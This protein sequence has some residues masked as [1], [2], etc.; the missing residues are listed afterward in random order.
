[1][2]IHKAH[3]LV[4]LITSKIKKNSAPSPDPSLKGNQYSDL[5]HHR[6]VLPVCGL[7]EVVPGFFGSRMFAEL[8]PSMF[9]LC[10]LSLQEGFPIAEIYHNVFIC[11]RLMDSM[12]VS[13]FWLLQTKLLWTLVACS[14]I[15][16][17]CGCL[18]TDSSAFPPVS[19]LAHRFYTLLLQKIFLKYNFDSTFLLRIL[20]WLPIALRVKS[21]PPLDHP[22]ALSA[23][24]NPSAKAFCVFESIIHSRIFALCMLLALLPSKR[25]LILAYPLQTHFY[26][27]PCILPQSFS[28]CFD[29]VVATLSCA[30]VLVLPWQLWRAYLLNSSDSHSTSWALQPSGWHTVGTLYVLVD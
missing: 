13:S 21:Q 24:L 20:R 26:L 8:H 17:L 3:T 28:S 4:C 19:P 10:S 18:P 27:L 12:V 16:A 5:Y 15:A 2:N 6:L 11:L 29:L 22:A 14:R 23:P 7:Y 30:C 9:V 1:M 25:L